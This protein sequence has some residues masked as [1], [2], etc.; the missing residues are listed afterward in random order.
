M[1]QPQDPRIQ[2]H[3]HHVS[4][5]TTTT[6]HNPDI[7]TNNTN[8]GE[9]RESAFSTCRPRPFP[10]LAPSMIPGRSSIWILAPR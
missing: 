10:S 4:A 6:P 9:G 8:T 3:T 5:T 7:I 1:G 2:L